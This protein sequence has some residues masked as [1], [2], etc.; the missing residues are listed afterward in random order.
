PAYEG[1][2]G[3]ADWTRDLDLLELVMATVSGVEAVKVCKKKES[4]K[5]AILIAFSGLITEDVVDRLRRIGFDEVLPKPVP[6]E[7]LALRIDEFLRRRQGAA[8][9]AKHGR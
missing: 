9:V 4:T 3:E 7:N 1:M 8:P 5:D 2:V 6:A